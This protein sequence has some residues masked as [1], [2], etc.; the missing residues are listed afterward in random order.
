MTN[1]RAFLLDPL[2]LQTGSCGMDQESLL[3]STALSWAQCCTV[4]HFPWKLPFFVHEE[5][6]LA[7]SWL[8][9]LK[10]RQVFACFRDFPALCTLGWGA[11]MGMLSR[12]SKIRGNN[13]TDLCWR[14]LREPS[15]LRACVAVDH[16]G[17]GKGNLK[18]LILSRSYSKE[19]S[20]ESER[21]ASHSRRI[22]T[23]PVIA[24]SQTCNMGGGASLTF[25]PS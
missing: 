8:C 4:R 19:A 23:S 24:G 16:P 12:A 1:F 7:L 14:D 17:D 18:F 11:S 15:T 13:Q 25:V 22:I 20:L 5:P 9:G 2:T 6:L 21:S 3:F 10:A